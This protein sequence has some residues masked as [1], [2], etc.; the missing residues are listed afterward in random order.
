LNH[1]DFTPT[2]A[3]GGSNAKVEVI[4]KRYA[5]GLPLYHPEDS[6]ECLTVEE[7]IQEVYQ[8]VIARAAEARCKKD[9]TPSAPF[10][11]NIL[12]E[13]KLPQIPT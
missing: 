4:A 7:K 9:P 6:P 11:S 8:A 1:P 3:P 2:D 10:L 13:L 12:Q 5:L